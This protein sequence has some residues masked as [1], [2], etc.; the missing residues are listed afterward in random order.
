MRSPTKL[1]IAAC[2]TAG[3]V[4]A[5]PAVAGACGWGHGWPPP[6]HHPRPP[7]SSTTTSSSTTSTSESTTTTMGN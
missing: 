7:C 3:T 1:L 6:H 2:I 5:G 4:G